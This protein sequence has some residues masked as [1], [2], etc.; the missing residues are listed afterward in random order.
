M[1]NKVNKN[2]WLNM[3]KTLMSIIFPLITYPYATRVLGVDNFGKVA[4]GSSI[5]SYFI[6]FAGLG[7]SN[8]AIREAGYIRE[9]KLKVTELVSELFTFNLFTTASSYFV[10]LLLLFT[11]PKFAS[12]R[13]LFL[14]QSISVILT[15]LG[16]E[17]INVIYEDYLYITIRSIVV[18][19]IMIVFLFLFVHKERDYII[20]AALQVLSTFIIT[21]SNLVHVRKKCKFK[22]KLPEISKHINS[23]LILFSNSLAVTIYCNVDITMVGWI[24]GDYEVG[25]YSLASK[26]YSILKQV[27]A[28][29][30]SVTVTRLSEYYATQRYEEYRSLLNNTL[31]NVLTISIPIG[32]GSFF[33]SDS[34]LY[35][36]GGSNYIEATTA[37]AILCITIVI[38]VFGGSIAFCMNMPLKREKY[39]LFS[40]VTGA[41]ENL[42]LN[43]YFIR[44]WGI[45]GAALTTLLAELT[46]VVILIHSIRDK[47]FFL[48]IRSLVLNA[49]KSLISCLPI[50]IIVFLCKSLEVNYVAT[51]AITVLISVVGFCLIGMLLHNQGLFNLLLLTKKDKN[52]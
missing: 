51:L 10:F 27:I 38:A 19:C 24:K 1:E 39:N 41:I 42:L 30:Y 28:A 3:I 48:N 6:L 5:I 2:M 15:T 8:Y 23:I 21:S 9:D 46:V 4:Y 20:Y 32:V 25:L 22:I 14:V 17:W 31:L 35:M 37:M 52:K 44:V 36:L 50:P 43:F 29:A 18:Q 11:I 40:T 34:L 47:L 12:Y 7:I 49:L 16:V 26:I 33:L 13:L 45:E